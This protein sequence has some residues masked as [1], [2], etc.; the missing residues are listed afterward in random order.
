LIDDYRKRPDLVEEKLLSAKD[1][2]IY[3]NLTKEE[4]I[5]QI[6]R[7][8]IKSTSQSGKAIFRIS[9]AAS[10]CATAC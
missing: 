2:L 3:L 7:G 8:E 10:S 1:L 9:S 5:G 4:L 6:N